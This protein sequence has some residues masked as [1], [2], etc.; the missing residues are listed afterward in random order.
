VALEAILTNERLRSLASYAF[1]RG[2][3]YF[4]SGRVVACEIRGNTVRGV[5]IGQRPYHVEVRID[6]RSLS[7]DCTC[8]MGDGF[9]KH[10]VA[11]ALHWRD[12]STTEPV[13]TPAAVG[14]V[15]ET[16][17]EAS[18]WAD[19]HGV[20]YVLETSAASL[21]G[22]LRELAMAPS[23]AHS[24][25]HVLRGVELAA[26]ASVESA[27]RVGGP[28]LAPTIAAAAR[29]AIEREAEAVA[30]GIAEEHDRG[31]GPRGGPREE[32]WARLVGLRRGLRKRAVPRGRQA[33][34][35][36]TLRFDRDELWVVWIDPLVSGF[37]NRATHAHLELPDGGTPQLD[38]DCG[39]PGG[40]CVHGLALVDGVL[41]RIAAPDGGDELATELLRPGWSRA[42]AALGDRSTRRASVAKSAK[43]AKAI[44]VWWVL[45]LAHGISLEPLVKKQ[46]KRGMSAGARVDVARLFAE[47]D[48]ALPPEDRAVADALAAW[49]GVRG[50][51]PVRAFAALVGHPRVLLAGVPTP[52]AVERSSLGF[53]A[54][55]ANR[56]LRLVPTVGGERIDPR[57]CAALLEA[58]AGP[59]PLLHLAY[60]GD[61]PRVQLIDVADDARHLWNVLARH[62]DEFP[63]ES[64]H[65]LFERLVELEPTLAIDVP[66]EL[67][68]TPMS[69][70][71]EVV[72]RVRLVEDATLELETFVRPAPGAPLYV[73]GAGPRDVLVAR[74]GERGYVRRRLGE[75]PAHVAGLLARLPME[76]AEQ[77]PP[78]VFRL[79]GD[80]A[81]GLALA[82]DSPPP[83]LV[84][85]WIATKPAIA[86]AIEPKALRVQIDV[87][88]DWFGIVG[89]VKIESGRLELAV[90]L[91]AARRQQRFVRVGAGR[92]AELSELLRTRLVA[93]ADQTYATKSRLELSPGA[94]PAVRALADAGAEVAEP[95]A[96]RLRAERLNAAIALRP[97]PPRALAATLR[98]Y[99]VEGHAWLM[100][101]AAW[102]AGACLADDM[103][104]GKTVQ[105]IAVMIDRAKLG[106]TLVLAPTS[107][108]YNWA[109]E[110]ARFAPSL[111]VVHYGAQT[112]RI[113]CLAQLGKRDVLV[114]SYGLLARDGELLARRK[115]ATLVVDEAQALKNATT[116]RARA[117]RALDADFRIALSGTPLEN[118]VGELW[119]V[120]SVVFPGL[121]GSWDQ[122]R[123]RYAIPIERS[124]VAGPR[125]NSPAGEL[126]R[127]IER[128]GV[129]GPRS[130]SPAGE[131]R[132][133]IETGNNPDAHA[134][135]SRV[136]RP[137]LLRRTK[138]EVASELP[139]RT[140][141][142]LPIALADDHMALYE[143]AR[144][145]AVAELS[146]A[147][148]GVRD[149]QRRFQVLAALT[150]LRLLACHPQL[151][152]PTSALGSA[153]LERLLEVVE[154]LRAEGHRALVFSQF[155]SHLG[156]VRPALEAA[157]HRVLYLDGETPGPRRGDLVRAF[158]DGKADVFLISLKAGGTGINLTAADYVIH[159]DPWWN[160]A[161]EDQATDRAHRIGQT[162]PVT[163][164]RLIAR[165]TIEEKILALHGDKRS[166]VAS[167][168]EGTS[169]AARLST[170]DLLALLE[171]APRA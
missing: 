137:F 32:L 103:G 123:D 92:W 65:E 38:C 122:F 105:A 72:A 131:L 119:S 135:L 36:G 125:S 41:D 10:A 42:L 146:D 30:A 59:E 54:I 101:L 168:L 80:A 16:G 107:V 13:A 17:D 145:A 96:W 118:H 161:V 81:L 34:A 55:S 48:A 64:H 144:L 151:Y 139:A 129:A 85:E 112:D 148:K 53:A 88:R 82:L 133:S 66:D 24:L 60:D 166:L 98:D 7:A 130:N 167:I 91:D 142:E 155:T 29:R 157:G 86:R 22:S 104:L 117:A 71:L 62:G 97:K 43:P 152:D 14:H 106:P 94:V 99:Q 57:V 138:Q 159:M 114:A 169:A 121:L 147:G 78:G 39:A 132:R 158:Q 90:L 83:G 171:G 28:R 67:K 149:E 45:D 93:L 9:C 4:R 15:F 27:R 18:R 126:R 128:S 75:E 156:L 77:G 162:R 31:A 111:R 110:V 165:G 84:A 76:T 153:K 46:T 160:P 49:T 63:P 26:V 69:G 74:D 19:Q 50:S 47:H 134:A 20:G 2:E 70:E 124:G 170:R 44:E 141:I 100:R 79:D 120:F 6:G 164:Y 109:A 73:P 102:G 116:R 150:R 61:T 115:F 154:E 108:G 87:E 68:G 8:P 113:A 3:G 12:A 51:Y 23:Y 136:I 21:M 95:P 127:S 56:G 11:L 37:S 52:I 25:D 163:V 5:V 143:D 58:F 33:R 40:A 35:D 89:D 1:A 140:E